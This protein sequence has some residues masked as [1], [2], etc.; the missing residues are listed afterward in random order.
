[1]KLEFSNRIKE[2]M[3]NRD[4]KIDYTNRIND[5]LHV[6][7]LKQNTKVRQETLEEY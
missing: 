5:R 4:K 7:C 2:Q 1:M 3:N 6:Q